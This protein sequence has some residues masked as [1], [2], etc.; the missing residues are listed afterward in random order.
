M[1]IQA[2]I[3][4]GHPMRDA[5]ERYKATPEYANTKNWAT[6]EPHTEGSLWA[7]FCAGH[8]AALLEAPEPAGLG[9]VECESTDDEIS[10]EVL[11]RLRP[12]MDE[13]TKDWPKQPP[14]AQASPTEAVAWL[15]FVADGD[16]EPDQALSFSKDSFPFDTV[17]GYR[18]IAPPRALAFVD[19]RHG[20]IGIDWAKPGADQTVEYEIKPGVVKADYRPSMETYVTPKGAV[21]CLACGSNVTPA[22]PIAA[23]TKAVELVDDVMAVIAE[24]RSLTIYTNQFGQDAVRSWISQLETA[25]SEEAPRPDWRYW[26]EKS[27]WWMEQAKRLGYVPPGD[28]PESPPP[29]AED[30]V[31]EAAQRVID[32]FQALGQAKGT[33]DTLCARKKCE[34][35]MNVLDE[36]LQATARDALS[37]RGGG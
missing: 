34:D 15:H 12:M 16:G 29:H 13:H 20:F 11:R 35:A 24:M 6:K 2:E 8:Q 31:R 14:P 5:W 22:Q 25:I 4:V 26:Y 1:S 30:G 23:Q 9:G 36:L 19:E 27:A 32:V 33:V 3:P 28:E 21:Y 10:E 7:A 37:Q 18:D 17:T